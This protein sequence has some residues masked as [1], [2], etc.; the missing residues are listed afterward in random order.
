MKVTSIAVVATL[1]MLML[2]PASA[3]S[4][5]IAIESGD[6]QATLTFG[7]ETNALDEFDQM[8]I[9]FPPPPPN[10]PLEAY[11]IS[12]GMFD[13]L[14]TDL[15]ERPDWIIS[16]KS[17]DDMIISWDTPPEDL[18]L[19]YDTQ[20]VN[21]NSQSELR[22]PEGAYQIHIS[23]SS[24]KHPDDT[25]THTPTPQPTEIISTET[26][27]HDESTSPPVAIGNEAVLPLLIQTETFN[28]IITTN[29][30]ITN[31]QYLQ[32]SDIEEIL[33]ETEPQ[34]TIIEDIGEV[35]ICIRAELQ[36][37]PT[38]ASISTDIYSEPPLDVVSA[39]R[40]GVRNNALQ[41][42]D[43]AYAIRVET[44]NL[45]N[46]EYLS[47]ATIEMSI[48]EEWAENHGGTES[49][50]I[51]RIADDGNFEVL[52][53]TVVKGNSEGSL[54]VQGQSPNGLSIFGLISVTQDEQ[55][56]AEPMKTETSLFIAP[57]VG[58]ILGIMLIAYL[59]KKKE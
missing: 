18:T 51:I 24:S 2:S 32:H 29:K 23:K 53:T 10:A 49:I 3:W 54:R 36:K 44:E 17:N 28:L 55:P 38:D 16:L 47:N 40:D 58:C 5:D 8:D 21:M 57:C 6:N 19:E 35:N 7:I 15:R 43:I 37:I 22:L 13:K 56:S 27:D 46:Y 50:R 1:C 41:L 52:K 12:T 31:Y 48:P 59:Q 30:E 4:N 42:N 14:S 26:N 20:T 9:P 11:F 33:I 25:A 39:I 34:S 45:N